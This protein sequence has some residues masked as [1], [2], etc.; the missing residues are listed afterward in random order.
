MA[1]EERL[2]NI[3]LPNVYSKHIHLYT[4]PLC[5]ATSFVRGQIFSDIDTHDTLCCLLLCL[6][7]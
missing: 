4:M 1:R 6:D 5:W 3:N 7:F 2:V